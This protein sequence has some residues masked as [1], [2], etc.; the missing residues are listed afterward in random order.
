MEE[1]SVAAQIW[2][3]SSVDMCEI[4]RNSCL[5]SRIRFG[6]EEEVAGENCDMPGPIGNSIEKQMS[7]IGE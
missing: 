1:Y 4:A 7:R 2:K 6:N 3:L 5:A